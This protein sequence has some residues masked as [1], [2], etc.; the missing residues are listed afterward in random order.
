MPRWKI[1][2]HY[3]RV[4]G[5]YLGAVKTNA[6]PVVD[7]LWCLSSLFRTWCKESSSPKSTQTCQWGTVV[8]FN[9]KTIAWFMIWPPNLSHLVLLVMAIP[10]AMS[11]SSSSVR[12]QLPNKCNKLCAE[13]QCYCHLHMP[14]AK[15]KNSHYRWENRG[16]TS[17]EIWLTIVCCIDSHTWRFTKPQWN[18]ICNISFLP[19]SRSQSNIGK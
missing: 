18:S 8:G 1:N 7:C 13:I 16:D 17:T 19:G 15:G 12:K 10:L 5:Q 2:C 9:E 11:D 4:L 3:G 6:E 14:K